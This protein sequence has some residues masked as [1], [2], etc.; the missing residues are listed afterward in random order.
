MLELFKY[1]RRTS[2]LK[3]VMLYA[4]LLCEI[5]SSALLIKCLIELL[6]SGKNGLTVRQ[7][8]TGKKKCFGFG[9]IWIQL[10]F[11]SFFFQTT[12]H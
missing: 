2:N 3:Y 6:Q 5:F 12:K 4:Q 8:A 10:L 7:F 9:N 1:S 11:F